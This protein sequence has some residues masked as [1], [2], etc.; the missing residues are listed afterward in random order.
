MQDIL[1]TQQTQKVLNLTNKTN[2]ATLTTVRSC[3]VLTP[4]ELIAICSLCRFFD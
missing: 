1:R 3:L 2:A 4:D